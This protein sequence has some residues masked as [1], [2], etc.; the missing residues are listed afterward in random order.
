MRTDDGLLVVGVG[1]GL[2]GPDDIVVKLQSSET[3]GRWGV[4]IVA[5]VPGEG[6]RTHLHRGEPEGFFVLDGEIELL[7]ASSRTPI[8]AGTFVLVPPDTEHGLRIV[9]A[10]PARW[11]AIWP[12]ALDGFVEAMRG[13]DP[14]DGAAAGEVR[15]RHGIVTGRD[16]RQDE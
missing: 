15:I 3:G 12:A 5:G 13:V 4:A 2:A 7:G 6:G 9:G 1:E 14:D 10:G 11:L 16:R 8:G